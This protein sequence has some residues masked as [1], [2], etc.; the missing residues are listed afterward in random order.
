MG[1]LGACLPCRS[2]WRAPV[3]AEV[4]LERQAERTRAALCRRSTAQNAGRLIVQ[5]V[6]QRADWKNK[7]GRVYTRD[8]LGREV[9]KY[10]LEKVERGRAYGEFDH[11]DPTT[12]AFRDL[13]VQNISHLVLE[14]H[15]EGENL[16][17][18]I[19]ILDTPAGQHLQESYRKGRRLGVSS[20]GWAT[21]VKRDEAVYI[22]ED[23]DLIA[24]DYVA[25][26]STYGAYM[27]P[28]DWAWRG[29]LQDHSDVVQEAHRV[30]RQHQVNLEKKA[31]LRKPPPSKT[32]RVAKKAYLKYL[33]GAPAGAGGVAGP[34]AMPPAPASA[35]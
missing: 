5:G 31:R 18:T 1:L 6:L 7:N 19:E 23:F 12:P 32:K 10:R 27:E 20:R 33:M 3:P 35:W 22:H 28:I 13:T 11:P 9:E 24:F 25:D 4:A 2:L 21:L 29:P 15:W 17:G 30:V 8:I 14:V 26:P 34:G 16:V